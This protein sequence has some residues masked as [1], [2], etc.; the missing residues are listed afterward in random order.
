M[1]AVTS[2]YGTINILLLVYT[3]YSWYWQAKL[4]LKGK[5]RVSVLIWTL[6][7]IWIGFSWD[8][9]GSIVP[10]IQ[11]FLALLIVVSIIDGYT[12]FA[13]KRVVVSGL[14]K[15]TVKYS[16]IKS[17]LLINVP[18]L[19]KPAVVCVLE[20]IKGTQ[21]NLQFSGTS[22]DVVQVLRKY[23]DHPIKIEITNTMP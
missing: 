12:G 9:I 8:Y 17:V 3:C 6:F 7:I 18:M 19:T 16:D 11:V 10:G 22:Q 5:Y 23:A 21:Y 15:R 20:T 4:E 13:A 14:F 1:A 2:F